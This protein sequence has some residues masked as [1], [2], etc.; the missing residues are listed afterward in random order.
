MD[1]IR[2]KLGSMQP[3]DLEGP[4]PGSGLEGLLD[5]IRNTKPEGPS[6]KEQAINELFGGKPEPK[7]IGL[8]DPTLKSSVEY[9]PEYKELYGQGTF[10][11]PPGNID[12][13][14]GR[15]EDLQRRIETRTRDIDKYESGDWK[16]ARG[17]FET[18]D[19]AKARAIERSQRD[20]IN[21][22]NQLERMPEI[23]KGMSSGEIKFTSPE[24]AK[25]QWGA[26]GKQTPAELGPFQDVSAEAY[27]PMKQ[28][29]PKITPEEQAAQWKEL[30]AGRIEEMFKTGYGHP[31]EYIS[32]TYHVDPHTG[33]WIPD[34]LV[35]GPHRIPPDLSFYMRNDVSFPKLRATEDIPGNIYPPMKQPPG[36]SWGGQSAPTTA[37][38]LAKAGATVAPTAL[39]AYLALRWMEDRGF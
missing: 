10:Y 23:P 7:G 11:E 12:A 6:L 15:I 3:P 14:R 9:S 39:A 33:Q 30:T 8:H 17:V 2:E 27:P 19:F 13:L 20:I 36:F 24:A 31:D 37:G 38:Q 28:Q 25:F 29:L 4:P 35:V 5:A 34:D 16:P 32:P 1:V 22:R 26:G 21:F 18:E